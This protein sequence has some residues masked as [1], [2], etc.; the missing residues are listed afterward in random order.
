[1]SGLDTYLFVI[2]SLL[3]LCA[4]A[5]KATGWLGIPTLVV[6]LVIGMLSGSE[7]IGGVEFEDAVAAQTLGIIALCYIL[8]SGGLDT[9]W[10]SIRPVL[11]EGVALSTLGVLLT[12]CFV[13]TFVHWGLGIELLPSF[14]IGAIISSTD[15]GAVFTVLRSKSIHLKGHLK[16]AL[17]LESGSN[18]PM[19]VFLTTMILQVMRMPESL[20]ALD[21]VS[22]FLQQMLIGSMV[23]IVLAGITVWLFSK[24]KLEIEGLY[25]VISLAVVLLIYSSAQSL[26]GNGFLAVYLAG[27]LM[28][29]QKFVL[30]KTLT[31]MHDGVSWLMQS[32][33]FLTLGLLIFPSRIMGV[34][35][36]GVLVSAFMILIARP[37]AVF[38]TLS[39]SQFSL[40]EKLLI[41]WVGLRGSVPVI[42]ATY[43]LVAG[44]PMAEH[45][46]NVVFFVA[47]TS[48][49]LQGTSINF[50]S[51]L[52]GLHS[53]LPPKVINHP[54][55]E[56]D[57]RDLVMVDVPQ[58]SPIAGKMIIEMNLDEHDVLIVAIERN[59]QVII[60][61][62]STVVEPG[63]RMSV[64]ANDASLEN[65][66]E[67]LWTEPMI[68]Q[69]RFFKDSWR[70]RERV[71]H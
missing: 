1:M 33:M 24:V 43:P 65:F 71:L 15:A 19:A 13:G 12:F 59:G 70:G 42:M 62:G 22:L 57:L 30:K 45:I 44:V 61:R 58:K 16:P 17:E 7:G 18:D 8:F 2:A 37:A 11:K 49:V 66:V 50:V 21:A 3:I 56:G 40:R 39:F 67:L 69:R 68:R 53:D 54:T 52:L 55:T 51:K 29:N 27:L 48:L 5:S 64:M 10:K 63:D 20:N 31:V 6:F 25:L 23:G 32:A 9:K 41:S 47:L 38:I 26:N 34:A 14:L 28:G 4:V 60:P 36:H 46:F 35:D